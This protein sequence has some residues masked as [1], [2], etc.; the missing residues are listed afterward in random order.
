MQNFWEFINDSK[1]RGYVTITE[2]QDRLPV[3]IDVEQIA[4]IS[5]SIQKLGLDIVSKAPNF[6]EINFSDNGVSLNNEEAGQENLANLELLSAQ[7]SRNGDPVKIYM[8]EMGA[9]DLLSRSNEIMVAKKIEEEINNM[10]EGLSLLPASYSILLNSYQ[11]YLDKNMRLPDIVVGFNHNQETLDEA[12]AR[13]GREAK[14]AARRKKS[15][16][17]GKKVPKKGSEEELF[18]ID[19]EKMNTIMA[20][21]KRSFEIFSSVH[22]RKPAKVRNAA[23]AKSRKIF[24]DFRF[25]YS[26]VSLLLD[27]MKKV[28]D[29][30]RD[31][32]RKLLTI[33]VTFGVKRKEFME[34]YLQSGI[35]K[36]WYYA[37]IKGAPKYDAKKFQKYA[38]EIEYA[39]SVFTRSEQACKLPIDKIKKLFRDITI[40][41]IETQKAKKA[42]IEANL[43]LVISI[44]KKYTSRGLNFLDLIQEGNLGLIKAV[45][46]FEYRRGYKFSTYATWWI[47]QA[48]TRSI[49]DQARTIRIPVHMI[50][51]INQLNKVSRSLLAQTGKEPTPEQLSKNKNT[52]LVLSEEKIRKALK[53]SLD[54]ISLDQMV[55]DEE[56]SRIGDFVP[57][58]NMVSPD[59]SIGEANIHESIHELLDTLSDKESKVLKMR[60]GVGVG[61]DHTL[62]EVGKHLGVTRERIRQ[63]ESK[64]LRKLRHQSRSQIIRSFLEES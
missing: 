61:K 3:E 23:F 54:P 16:I 33:A 36:S 21:L 39:F 13:A 43:R 35:S 53:I 62:E 22:G 52:K 2:V 6:N 55:G 38:T 42:M 64:A 40:A 28:G 12:V 56:N 14:F 32:E 5:E 51:T 1:S 9:V 31:E 50:E 10:L 58:V 37:T 34:A 60:F 29:S 45:D 19:E 49:A 27:N 25:A 41:K 26:F 17:R 4:E 18:Q 44:A 15:K 11:D 48:I 63:I 24:L 47:R 46:K 20:S 8:S 57:D 59:N 30:I 7:G